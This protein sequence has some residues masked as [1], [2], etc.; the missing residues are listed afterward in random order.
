M[1]EMSIECEKTGAET[2]G[3]AFYGAHDP[4]SDY[5]LIFRD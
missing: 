5:I 4:L 3:C 2:S 1:G